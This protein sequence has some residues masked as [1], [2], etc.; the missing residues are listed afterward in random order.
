MGQPENNHVLRR[1]FC[2]YCR[3]VLAQIFQSFQLDFILFQRQDKVK[4][5]LISFYDIKFRVLEASVLNN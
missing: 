2:K 5:V 4:V 1:R 3:Q